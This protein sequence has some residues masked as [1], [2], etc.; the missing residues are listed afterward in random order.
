MP[1]LA[2]L[3]R[4]FQMLTTDAK[5]DPPR[6]NIHD[7]SLNNNSSTTSGPNGISTSIV[8]SEIDSI[9]HTNNSDDHQKTQSN[10]SDSESTFSNSAND[11]G[12]KPNARTKKKTHSG[13][14]LYC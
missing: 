14:N 7:N 10:L 11:R 9:P 6:I 13:K 5:P 1:I 2:N 4:R 12:K 8:S 3:S